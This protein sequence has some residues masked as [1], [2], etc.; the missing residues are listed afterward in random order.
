MDIKR[1]SE[2]D[3]FKAVATV[4]PVAIGMDAGHKSFQLYK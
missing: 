3:L 1:D 4:G 2:M